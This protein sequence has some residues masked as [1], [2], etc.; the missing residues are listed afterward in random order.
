MG[1]A[2]NLV[3]RLEQ[4][5]DVDA[6]DETVRAA[7]AGHPHSDGSEPAIVRRLR[8]AGD[9]GVALVALT[10]G[11]VVGQVAFSPVSLTPAAPAWYGLGPLSVHPLHQGRGIGSALVRR[12]LDVL[13]AAGAGGCVVFGSASFYRR[14]GFRAHE[15]LTYPG[16]PAPLFLALAF[17]GAVPRATVRY[18]A[19]F[20]AA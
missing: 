14:F 12:G 19:A 16:A 2:V 6:I 9:L 10:Q 7:F 3:I 4:A 15:Q 8:A 5:C 18:A 20:D 11:R 17:D 1:S 13:R